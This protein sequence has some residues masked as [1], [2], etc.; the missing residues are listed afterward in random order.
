MYVNISTD[1]DNE[2]YLVINFEV[3]PSVKK[4]VKYIKGYLNK[5]LI[6]LQQY[7]R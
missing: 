3:S 2:L 6:R 1:S 5:R 7:N 4:N